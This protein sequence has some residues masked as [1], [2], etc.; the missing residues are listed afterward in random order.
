M[1]NIT[2]AGEI[3]FSGANFADLTTTEFEQLKLQSG[4]IIFNRTNSTELV[5]KAACWRLNTDAVVASY[6]VRLR[7][8]PDVI[9]E[10]FRPS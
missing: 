6:L 7:L 3:D 4:D 5:G 10:F 1:G 8:K 9:P 2:N